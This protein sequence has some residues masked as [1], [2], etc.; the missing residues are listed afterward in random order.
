MV[1]LA[2]TVGCAGH[3]GMQQLINQAVAAA[4]ALTASGVHALCIENENDHPHTIRVTPA[5]EECVLQAVR[6]IADATPL[7]LGVNILLND[8]RASLRV[9]AQV[10]QCHFIRIDVFVDTVAQHWPDGRV[11]T[12]IPPGRRVRAY[13]HQINATRIALFTDIQVK[14]KTM[15]DPSKPLTTSARQA[16]VTGAAALVVTGAATGQPTPLDKIKKVKDYV[17]VHYPHI[18]V[19]VGAGVN[20]KNIVGQLSIADGAIIGT[21]FKVTNGRIDTKKAAQIT[22]LIKKL[23]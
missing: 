23:V 19:L 9:A 7:P 3:H 8:W 22:K 16:I 6:A 5:Q 20:K 21:A 2:P 11:A 12:I 1:H 10:P 14:H 13:A 15:L 18:P 17:W 4:R